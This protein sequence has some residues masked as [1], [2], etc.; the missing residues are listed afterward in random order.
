MNK[1]RGLLKMTALSVLLLWSTAFLACS[2]KS[3]E[4]TAQTTPQ[5]QA[6]QTAHE[7]P[8]T[9]AA[10]QEDAKKIDLN[11][12]REYVRDWASRKAFPETVS[13]AYY[14]AYS[15]KALDNKISPDTREKIID[16]IK[17]CQ[18][19]DGGFVTEPEF[20]KDQDLL[21]TY[22]AL[23]TLALI[24]ATDAINK[25]QA[26]KFVLSLLQ[27][28]GGFKSDPK[29]DYHSLATTYYG[30][31]SL[32]HLGA[33]DQIDKEKTTAYINSYREKGQGF[34]VKR[35]KVS[36]PISTYMAVRSLKL[37]DALDDEVKPDI[38][39]YLKGT[40]YSGLVEDGKYTMQPTM[41][42]MAFVLKALDDLSAV[43][44][45]NQD[46]V[47][48]FIESLYIPDNGGFGPKP[49]YGT[50]PPSIYEGI[51]SLEKLG[52]LNR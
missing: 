25:E 9:Q 29:K 5:E 31:T 44:E 48:E 36:R 52:K 11:L 34:S 24:D 7:E 20:S 13:F 45:V 10:S 43:K 30:V 3:Q 38:V 18:T 2:E 37:L 14:C 16:Y 39:K 47:Y 33:M 40:R 26:V 8:A 28:D 17:R 42:E 12:T 35:T 15:L 6:A 49:S 4:Q 51:L 1:I 21:S 32:Y 23:R 41:R 46:K 50:T 19:D 22:F 27:E